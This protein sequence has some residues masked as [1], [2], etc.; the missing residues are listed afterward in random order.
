MQMWFSNK[1]RVFQMKQM[2]NLSDGFTNIQHLKVA[3]QWNHIFSNMNFEMFCKISFL[4]VSFA[5]LVA[6]EWS[7]PRV[8]PHV[9]LQSIR[10]SASVVA[11]VTFERL[12][13]CV[14]THNMSF[15]I[16]SINARIIA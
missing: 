5:A 1:C 16:T 3:V 14:H 2:V 9:P 4:L 6:L 11:L 10:N 13:S 7:L 8:R 12:L 15:Q